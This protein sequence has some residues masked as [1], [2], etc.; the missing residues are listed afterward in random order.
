VTSDKSLAEQIDEILV[1]SKRPT[2]EV[3]NILSMMRRKHPTHFEVAS[4]R[5]EQKERDDEN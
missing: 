5:I 1:D 4:K 2:K 3:E